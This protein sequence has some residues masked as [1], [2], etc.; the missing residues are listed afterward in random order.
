MRN[1]EEYSTILLSKI[2]DSRVKQN[3]KSLGEK[4]L[5]E[6]SIQLW[7]LSADHSTYNRYHDMLNGSLKNGIDS[8]KLNSSLLA[9]KIP[10]FSGL[11]YVVFMHDGCDIGKAHSEHLE[12]L[13]WVR[14]GVG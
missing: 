9:D 12:H 10:K 2:K 13:G 11:K 4:I 8:S 14:R 6:H 5:S 7:K 1:F 3:F